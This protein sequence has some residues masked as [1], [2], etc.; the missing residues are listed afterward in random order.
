M[1]RNRYIQCSIC[2]KNIRSDKMKNHKH[3]ENVNMKKKYPMKSCRV[4]EKNMIGKHLVRHMKTH[5]SSFRYSKILEDMRSDQ[6][7]IKLAREDG[8]FIKKV[9]EKEKIDETTLRKEHYRALKLKAE[10]PKYNESLRTWQQELLEKLIPSDREIIW[11]V[12]NIG[13]E[14][15]TWFQKFLVSYFGP[16]RTFSTDIEKRSDGLLHALSKRAH[17]L[18]DVFIFNV[19]RS[20]HIWHVPYTLLEKIKDGQAISTKYDSKSLD[21]KT[22]NIVLVF[23]NNPPSLQKMSKDRWRKFQISRGK[24]L[25]EHDLTNSNWT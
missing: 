16:S 18:I 23:S 3:G 17:S 4:C 24:N 14:G 2:L 10:S 19:A 6:K 20:F 8:E 25:I 5:E 21:F 1:G 15:K 22:P 9:I 7:K 12:G 11:V 13:N